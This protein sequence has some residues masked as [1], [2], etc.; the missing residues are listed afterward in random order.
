MTQPQTHIQSQAPFVLFCDFGLPYTGQMKA[1]LCGDAPDTPIIDLF[2]DVPA[3]DIEAGSVLLAAHACDFPLGSI[4]LCVVD[5]GVGTDQ[6]QPGVVFAGGRWFVGPLNGL[7]EHVLRRYGKDAQAFEIIADQ[8]FVSA[9]FHGRDIFAPTAARLAKGDQ[10]RLKPIMLKS[11][12]KADFQDDVRAVIYVDGFGNLMT[13]MRAKS[14]AKGQ[15]VEVLGCK[16]PMVRTFG[17][18]EPGTLLVYENAVGLLE[19]AAS[20]ASAHDVLCIS[21]LPKIKIVKL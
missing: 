4:F 19:I 17:D 5:P 20:Q 15:T 1:R 21:T 18:V 12:R 16:L 10:S 7:F 3:F 6:R 13:G 14:L 11:I 2:H 8:S 9:T